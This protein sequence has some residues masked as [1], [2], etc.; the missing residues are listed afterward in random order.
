MAA[1]GHRISSNRFDEGDRFHEGGRLDE[2][3]GSRGR[4]RRQADGEAGAALG[5]AALDAALDL[6]STGLNVTLD[7]GPAR[8]PAKPPT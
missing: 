1:P 8:F 4:P 7:G 6:T 2:G 3:A 5:C